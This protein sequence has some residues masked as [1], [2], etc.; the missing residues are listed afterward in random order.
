M[1]ATGSSPYG[2]PHSSTSTAVDGPDGDEVR[3]RLGLVLGVR[4]RPPDGA[5]GSAAVRSGDAVPRRRPRRLPT[6]LATLGGWPR[7]LLAAGL[8]IA[9]LVVG[10]RGQTA[11]TDAT[12][13]GPAAGVP[14]LTVARDLAAGTPLTAAHVRAVTVPA[15]LVPTGALRPP[16][17]VVGRLV[18]AGMRRGEVLTDA[19]LVGPGLAAGLSGAESTAV[20][21]RLADGQAAGLVRAGD[22]VDILAT[23]AEAGLPAAAGPEPV[24]GTSD[25]ARAPTGGSGPAGSIG[26]EATVVA[27]G[28]RVLAVLSRRD[29]AAD[30]GALIVVAASDRVARRLVGASAEGRLGVTLRPP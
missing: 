3:R 19:R 22:R 23:R 5:G 14:V 7:R 29:S 10:V 1:T 15:G 25:P 24:T 9:A 4:P 21:V 13:V 8:L 16:A 12:D 11:P 17:R 26:P 18:A 27:A 2:L 20:P 28:V 30:E 6:A